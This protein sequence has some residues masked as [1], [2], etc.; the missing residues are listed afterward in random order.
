[1][2]RIITILF[3]IF[4]T[5]TAVYLYTNKPSSQIQANTAIGGE[6]QLTNHL[7]QPISND[8]LK[9]KLRLVYFGFTYCP[10][11]C[12][13]GLAAMQKALEELRGDAPEALFITVDPERDTVEHLATYME[14]FPAIL[15]VTGTKEQIKQVAKA[16]RI[17]YKKIAR[18]DSPE[19]YT[20]D[21]TSL[22]YLMDEEGYYLAHFPHTARPQDLVAGIRKIMEGRS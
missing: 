10:D 19:D 16:Y 11:I 8:S 3:L 5:A 2:L 4:L 15:G 18:E 7:G 12:P 21:H 17:Y 14:N 22:I 13:T 6:F 20:M 9:G 1:M